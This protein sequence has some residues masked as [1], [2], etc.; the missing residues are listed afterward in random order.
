MN[1]IEALS[2]FDLSANEAEVYVEL[3][4]LGLTTAGPII[5]KTE[6]HRQLVYNALESLVS[7]GLVTVQRKNNRKHFQASSPRDLFKSL[8]KK[9]QIAEKLVPELSK[10]QKTKDHR[11][12]VK[13]L[14]GERSFW[15]NLKE[16][17]DS[18][19]NTDSVMRIVGGASDQN[20]YDSLGKEYQNYVEYCEEKK[21]KKKL[22]APKTVVKGFAEKFLKEKKSELRFLGDVLTSPTYT[23]ITEELVTIEMYKPEIVV[24]QIYNNAIAQGYLENFEF[25]W[26]RAIE[27]C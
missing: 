25:M 24:I 9:Q 2:N 5:E 23:R 15:D 11:L 3:L 8:E 17:A 20:F 10:L 7:S 12:E 1:I 27:Y 22:L 4:G 16:V 14:F 26:E 6:L 18:A 13:T 21:I 19:A